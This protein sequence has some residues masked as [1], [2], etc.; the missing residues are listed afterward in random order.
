[1]QQAQALALAEDE[2]ALIRSLILADPRLVLDDDKVMRALIGADPGQRNVVDLRDRLVARMEERLKALLH[3]NRSVIAAAYE[4]VATTNQVHRAVL[5][6]AEAPS[7]NAFL[8]RLTRE[9]PTM[10]GVEEA[11]LCL[12]A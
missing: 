8:D 7:L 5:A 4:N 11:R 9:V 12:E 6:L 2:Q 10:L 1:M 3:T